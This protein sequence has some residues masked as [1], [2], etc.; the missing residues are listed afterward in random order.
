MLA[1]GE[2]PL[3][4][5]LRVPCQRHRKLLSLH[6]FALPVGNSMHL[7][8]WLRIRNVLVFTQF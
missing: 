6:R 2:R 5:A 4:D 7:Y 8:L 1:F 3:P